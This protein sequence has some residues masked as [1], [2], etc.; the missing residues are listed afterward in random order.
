MAENLIV[1]IYCSFY[2]QK[3]DLYLFLLLYYYFNMFSSYWSLTLS[4]SSPEFIE[5][6]AVEDD[7][8]C[9]R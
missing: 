7:D 6:G 3:L 4:H 2:S 1:F 5:K 9:K 8:D